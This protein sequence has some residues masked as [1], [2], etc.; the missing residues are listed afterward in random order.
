FFNVEVV[1]EGVGVVQ[2]SRLVPVLVAA[3]DVKELGTGVAR[4]APTKNTLGLTGQRVG[5]HREGVRELGLMR[6]MPLVLAR[7]RSGL[8]ETEVHPHLPA[9]SGG[10]GHHAVDHDAAVL[11]FVETPTEQVALIAPTI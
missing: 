5:A 6:E 4:E 2:G 10:V 7:A 3:V 11:I 1:T 8:G 9:R